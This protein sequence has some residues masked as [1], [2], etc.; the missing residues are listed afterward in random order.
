MQFKFLA[1][2]NLIIITPQNIVLHCLIGD[3]IKK[4]YQTFLKR[5]K[6]VKNYG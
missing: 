6:E 5:A 2:S 1:L 3:E 4:Y